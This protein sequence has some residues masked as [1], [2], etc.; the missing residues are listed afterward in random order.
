MYIKVVKSKTPQLQ[1]DQLPRRLQR[2]R[3]Q[4]GTTDVAVP[5]ANRVL[6][7]SNTVQLLSL[8]W[9]SLLLQIIF[10][11]FNF[12][13]FIKDLLAFFAVFYFYDFLWLKFF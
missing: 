9:V 11:R 4:S 13:I 1:P 2:H 7:R 10:C 6:D 12:V 8:G 5:V 3:G